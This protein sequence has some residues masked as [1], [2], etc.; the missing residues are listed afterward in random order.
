MP[1]SIEGLPRAFEGLRILHLSDLHLR[2]YVTVDDLAT[3]LD[4]AKSHEPH[5]VVV[6]GDVAD[7]LSQLP[8]ALNMVEELKSPLG[9]F[10]C[11][12]NHEYFRGLNQ[13]RQFF[14]RSTVK[15]L[16]NGG[17][18]LPHQDASLFIGGIDDPR[19]LDG[20]TPDFF[21]GCLETTFREETGEDLRLLLSHRPDVFSHVEDFEVQLTLSGHTHGGQVGMFGRSAFENLFPG[22]Y[23]WGHYESRGRHL[24]TSSGVGHWFPFRLG[25]PSEAPVIELVSPGTV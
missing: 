5:L 13:V 19:Y 23:L 1:L 18:H 14:E 6:T 2:H 22:N 12:G 20:A 16:I 11:L 25:C 15:L 24:Y 9:A 21:R 8:Q 3:V 7:D 17:I 4:E 10:A